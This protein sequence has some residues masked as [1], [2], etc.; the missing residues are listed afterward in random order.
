[1]KTISTLLVANR[2]EIAVRVMRT[3]R[4][5][6]IRTV[7]VYSDADEDALHVREADQA[8]RLGGPIV[9]ESYLNQEKVLA[10]AIEAGVD[11]IH[12]GYGFLS[13]NSNFAA[14]CEQKNI[15][16]IGPPNQAIE[17]MGDKARA[18][19]AMLEAD[20]PCIPGYQDEAQDLET[21]LS[22]AEQIGLPVMIKAA[23]GGGG[24]GMRLVTELSQLED[25]IGLAQSEAQN[26]FGSSELIIERAVLRPRHVEVQVFADQLGHVVHLGE[27]DC[28][29]QRRHQK[30]IEESPCPVMTP[31]LRRAMGEA[32]V[33]V[34]RAVDY[35]GAGTVE[36]L[37]DEEGQFY[38][39]EMNTRLQVEHPVTELVTGYDLVEWQIRVARG[40][41]LPAEQD[42]I[43]LLGHAIE[44]RLY[45][46]EPEKGF[47]PSTGPVSLF[48]FPEAEG[49][50]V[51][52]G[53]ASG[54]EVSPYYDAMVAKIIG[55]GETREDARRRLLTALQDGALLGLGNN[56]NFLIN[57]LE[58]Q[59]FKEGLATTAFIAEY[60]GDQFSAPK[61][62]GSFVAGGAVIQHLLAM[63]EAHER[64]PLV[65][66]ELL[67]WSSRGRAVSVRD[68][69]ID[70]LE[71]S[72]R[73]EILAAGQYQVLFE[74]EE[75]FVEFMGMS[76]TRCELQINGWRESFNFVHESPATLH[77]ANATYSMILTDYA[78]VSP[79]G[80]DAAAGGTVVAPMHGLL[81]AVEVTENETVVKGQ[82][83]A[84]LEAMKMQHEI[85][86]PADGV[87]L[88]TPGVA[89]RQVAAGDVM[90]VLELAE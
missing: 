24:R 23:A 58:Q 75:F 83:L 4:A 10:A 31:E 37:V 6:G 78:R 38:F 12:P 69:R 39:L 80:V 57:A 1:M 40:E 81:L 73:L 48:D 30:V 7:A 49:I 63:G 41:P 68:Y 65:S 33:N 2:G 72:V 67:D 79:E 35:V 51:D 18:K 36:F 13:E 60:Y 45:A 70:E 61:V 19:R 17:V 50:R 90:V 5:L 46:E 22:A 71:V 74:S 82:R 55:Y 9:S 85:I 11:A 27:R 54:D 44:V 87:V 52:S 21:L 8:I 15:V 3:A 25:A 32:A 29:I 20:V 89:G 42:D 26:A 14:A 56:R 64:A 62:Q 59:S 88:E 76:D 86:A 66:H 28:S 84:V 77:L 47:L 34:A 53:V 43:E 16:F